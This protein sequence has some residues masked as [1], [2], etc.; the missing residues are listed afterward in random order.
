MLAVRGSGKYWAILRN[1]LYRDASNSST[2]SLFN[3]AVSASATRRSSRLRGRVVVT[4]RAALGLGNDLVDA[5][6]FV[7]IGGGD[8][9]RL[10]REFFFSWSRHMMEAQPSGEMTE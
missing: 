10:R 5:A 4:V 9:Q 1:F 3:V 6:H 2:G 7:Q 8:A